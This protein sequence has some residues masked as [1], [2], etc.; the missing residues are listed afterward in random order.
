[1]IDFYEMSVHKDGRHLFSTSAHSITNTQE[2]EK[3]LRLFRKKFP[4]FEG[5][6]VTH[7]H[8][9]SPN[10]PAGFYRGCSLPINRVTPLPG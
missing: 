7:T 9:H 4:S 3:N 5:Y 2:L 8:W 6:V 1:M 10:L